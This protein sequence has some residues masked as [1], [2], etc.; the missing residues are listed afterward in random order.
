MDHVFQAQVKGKIKVSLLVFF[1]TIVEGFYT[2]SPQHRI[3]SFI[4][5]ALSK[6][7]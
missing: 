4:A 3:E 1:V 5:H 7:Y 2:S 6:Q